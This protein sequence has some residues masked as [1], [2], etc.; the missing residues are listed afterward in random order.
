MR[1][2][3]RIDE[4]TKILAVL[5]KRVPDWRL[6]QL[7]NNLQRHENNDLFYYEDRKLL[8][9]I[10]DMLTELKLQEKDK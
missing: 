10:E 8:D 7:L 2:I 1:D 9:A 3:N 4:V 6:G 5:W